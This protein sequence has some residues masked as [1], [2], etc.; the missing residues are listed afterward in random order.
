MLYHLL[1]PFKHVFIGFNLFKYITFRSFCAAFTAMTIYFVF[2]QWFIR[3]LQGRKVWQAVRDDGPATHLQKKRVPTMGG[4]LMWG[5]V[6]VSVLLWSRLDQPFVLLGLSLIFTYGLIGFLDDYRKVVLRDS[7]G[8]RARWKFPMQIIA[9]AAVVIF[10]ADYLGFDRTLVVP[11]F[12]KVRPDLGMFY[13]VFATLVIV[14]AS[15]A[16]NLTDGLDG[17]VSFPSIVSFFAYGI[18]CYIAGHIALS[19]Y[20]SVPYIAGCGELS[21]MCGAIVGACMAFLWYNAHPASIFLGDVGALPLGAILGYVALVSKNE[22]L[23]LVIGGIFVL[24]AV[25]V[26]A[27]VVSFKLTRKRV[28]R[29][30][31]IHHHFELIGWPE[32]KVIVRFWIISFILALVSLVTLKLR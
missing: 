13:P 5:S 20:L 30:A 18:L 17:L 32:S 15:N 24:E 19:E 12:K 11:F 10:L 9:A 16:V 8:L 25:S 1:Y 31:P 7:H 22:L 3:W 6:L 4:L 26:I 2:G 14:G 27:Q 21:V 29:M 23:L 28:L